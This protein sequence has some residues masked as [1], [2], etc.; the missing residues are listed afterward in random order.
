MPFAHDTSGAVLAL[1]DAIVLQACH[2][3]H[4]LQIDRTIFYLVIGMCGVLT[5]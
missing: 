4:A 3:G 5:L 1:A 2:G